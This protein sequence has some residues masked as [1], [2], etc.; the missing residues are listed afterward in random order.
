LSKTAN[1]ENFV[2]YDSG[3]G[4]N[5]RI[6]IFGTMQNL[7]ILSTCRTWLADGTFDTAPSLFS[8]IYT[9]H[10]IKHGH[11]FP[12]VYALLPDKTQAT[13]ARMVHALK[14][15]KPTLDPGLILV[16]YEKAAINVFEM[17]FPRARI[18]GCFF[19][20]CQAVMRHIQSAGLKERYETDPNF[21]LSMRHL[22]ALAFVPVV[23]GQDI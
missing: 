18:Q 9:I 4:D 1:D 21:A 17:E 6:L 20:L 12:L 22:T 8:Q 3:V 5:N 14:T 23:E 15:L 2:L 10:G 11:T 16:D 13:Y 19:H 7:S